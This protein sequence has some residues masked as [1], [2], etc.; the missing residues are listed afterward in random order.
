MLYPQAKELCIK[1]RRI[2]SGRFYQPASGLPLG[3]GL[4]IPDCVLSLPHQSERRFETG[5]GVA[6][7]L[8]HECDI[9]QKNERHFN[10]LFL[11]SPVIFL[12]D[13][14]EEME[15]ESGTGA[16]GGILP[17]I[18]NDEVYRALYLPPVPDYAQCPQL[19]G[20]GIVYLN[21]ISPCR[22][23]WVQDLSQQAICSLSATGL[24]A[25]DAT[26]QNHMFRE[27]AASL[28]F[29]R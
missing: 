27:K 23:Q 24:R 11:V 6:I 21:H 17:A 20:G 15:H 22:I 12:D 16:W 4:L 26:L 2:D 8:T 13:F 1:N 19:E 3:T 18:A 28:W 5:L 9:D 7:V 25:F 14:C 29:A 10:D